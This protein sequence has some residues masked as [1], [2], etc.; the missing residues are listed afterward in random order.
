MPR[1]TL[2]E[3]LTETLHLIFHA[4]HL[5]PA[6][7]G[8]DKHRW[9]V[10][11]VNRFLETPRSPALSDLGDVT[12]LLETISQLVELIVKL[13]NLLGVFRR[14]EPPDGGSPAP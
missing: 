13:F 9:V 7:S 10:E 6:G 3:L 4:E 8:T 5:Y 14:S 11:K 12:E 2:L 1:E